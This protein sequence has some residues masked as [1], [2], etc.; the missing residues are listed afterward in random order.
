VSLANETDAI[1]LASI[2]RRRE[3]AGYTLVETPSR[4]DFYFG[5]LL[6]LA[7][8]PERA[9]QPAWV[10]LHAK[11]FAGTGIHR[12]TIVWERE[13]E[14]GDVMTLAPGLDGQLERSTVFVR[15][16]PFEEVRSDATVRE[17]EDE[18]DWARAAELNEAE[19]D[20]FA[21]PG[22]VAFARWRFGVWHDDARTGRL[23]MWGL[24]NGGEFVA[25]AGIYAAGQ[26]ARFSTPVTRTSF[27]RRG[28][29]R[30]LCATAVNATLRR[31]PGTQIVICAATGEA[32]EAIYRHL[33]FRAVGAQFGLVCATEPCGAIG[34]TESR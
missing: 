24:W 4:R 26:L 1:V 5:N 11:L 28:A 18:A 10:R 32:P 30:T 12:H 14:G 7:R 21:A 6:V 15:N 9:A 19:M 3:Y 16:A 23:R 22:L 17:L 25:F 34:Y 27:R 8:E 13:G 31:R 2:T 33:G 29:F 20:P